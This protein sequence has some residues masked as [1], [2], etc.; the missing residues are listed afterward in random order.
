MADTLQNQLTKWNVTHISYSALTNG[1][2]Y[3]THIRTNWKCAQ[4]A[5][6]AHNQASAL[7]TCVRNSWQNAQ[8]ALCAQKRS[9]P[10]CTRRLTLFLELSACPDVCFHSKK[11]GI[12]WQPVMSRGEIGRNPKTNGFGSYRN[13]AKCVS[14][15]HRGLPAAVLVCSH[16]WQFYLGKLM[17]QI[18]WECSLPLGVK[19][20][21]FNCCH[22]KA[23]KEEWVSGKE[24]LLYFRSQQMRGR[25][26]RGEWAP[27]Q[28]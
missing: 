10:G 6:C 21:W 15:P 23:N 28:R 25:V 22:S 7:D 26:C 9:V 3:Q 4:I 1:P 13:V 18:A 8:I 5:L 16:G 17:K 27:V 19:E 12:S 20:T 11:E 14:L 24:S 2:Q